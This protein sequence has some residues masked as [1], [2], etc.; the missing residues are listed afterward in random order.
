MM[1]TKAFWRDT[2]ERAIRSA[3]T[4]F[5]ATASG[6]AILWDI[7]WQLLVG[8]PVTAA[9]LEVAIALSGSKIGQKGTASLTD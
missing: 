6:T 2:S 1:F 7:H 8:V 4:S 9:V 3:A 5:I